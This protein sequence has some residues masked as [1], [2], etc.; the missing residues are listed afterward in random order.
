MTNKSNIYISI[1]SITYAMKAEELL[2]SLGYFCRVERTPKNMGSGCGYSL[3]VK[4]EPSFITAQLKRHGI[5]Y[6]GVYY[7]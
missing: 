7:S 3:R 6:R 2:S 1:G 4:D 5:P